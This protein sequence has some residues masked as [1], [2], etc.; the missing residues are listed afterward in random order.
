VITDLEVLDAA[1]KKLGYEENDS[2]SRAI[3][4]EDDT[5]AVEAFAAMRYDLRLGRMKKLT[6]KQ[7]N[8]ALRIADIDERSDG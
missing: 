5:H 8:W 6:T 1:L 2:S 3:E 4:G 7:R